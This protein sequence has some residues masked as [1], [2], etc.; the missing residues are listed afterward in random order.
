LSR[1]HP[2]YTHAE[3]M[4]VCDITTIPAAAQQAYETKGRAVA[5][6]ETSEVAYETSLLSQQY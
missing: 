1:P 6:V 2:N 4:N 3:G 5:A